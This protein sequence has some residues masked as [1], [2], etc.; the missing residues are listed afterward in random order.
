M[1]RDDID[2]E[3]QREPKQERDKGNSQAGSKRESRMTPEK[4]AKRNTIVWYK[5]IEEV[6]Q[7]V[8]RNNETDTLPNPI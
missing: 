5:S 8:L 2:P 7:E 6:K 3:S 1:K 4:Q